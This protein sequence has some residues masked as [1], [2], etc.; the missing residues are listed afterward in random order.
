[1]TRYGETSRVAAL[2]RT[3]TRDG[4]HGCVDADALWHPQFSR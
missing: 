1:V 2:K 3:A 4:R